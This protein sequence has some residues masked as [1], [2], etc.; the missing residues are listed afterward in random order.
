MNKATYGRITSASLAAWFGFALT[1]SALHL[2]QTDPSRP[3]VALG[4]AVL[5]PIGA[6]L[7]CFP[8]GQDFSVRAS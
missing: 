5:I 2:F 4:L 7:L 8:S 1:A 6:F 3:P